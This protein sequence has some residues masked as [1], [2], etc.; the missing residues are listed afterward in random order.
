MP[1][2]PTS[3]SIKPGFQYCTVPPEA[4]QSEG[5]MEAGGRG[6]RRKP[7]SLRT[8]VTAQ[9]G[10]KSAAKDLMGST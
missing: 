7:C 3:R 2:L 8:D 9:K 4:G 5:S 10:L 6:S 1:Q